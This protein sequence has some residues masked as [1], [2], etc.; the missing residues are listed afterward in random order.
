MHVAKP[1]PLCS[2]PYSFNVVSISPNIVLA[3]VSSLLYIFRYARL[4][5]GHNSWTAVS[6]FLAMDFVVCSLTFGLST[7]YHTFM[8]HEGG[9]KVYDRLLYFDVLGV[10][11]LA[12]FATLPIIYTTFHCYPEL[13]TWVF[14]LYMGVSLLALLIIANGGSRQ[15]RAIAFMIQYAIR[16]LILACRLSPLAAGVPDNIFYYLLLEVLNT[17]S[18]VVNTL[19]IPER[20]MSGRFDYFLNGHQLMHISTT[21]ALFVFKTGFI[22]D[23]EWV[24]SGQATTSCTTQGQLL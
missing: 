17:L 6:Y 19:H 18:V 1:H 3:V 12:T 22:I 20:W 23:M 16:L 21:T 8:C 5:H 11:L 10:W 9:R 13:R 2:P 24:N 7:I 14:M 4:W 15:H